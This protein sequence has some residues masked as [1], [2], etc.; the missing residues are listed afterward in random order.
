MKQLLQSL[1]DGKTAVE[2]LPC[3]VVDRG[4]VLIATRKTLISTG[5]EKMLV[6]FGKSGIVGKARQQPDKVR[7]VLE[8]IRTDGLRPTIEAVIHKLDQPIPLGYCNVGSVVKAGGPGT[9]FSE[10]DRVVCN[11]KHAEIVTS[12]TN[13]CAKVPDSVSDEE[14]SLTVIAAIALQGVRLLKPTLGECVVVTGLGLV[15]LITVQL[16][17]ANGCRVLGIDFDP[18]RL[19]LARKFGAETVDLSAGQDP[20]ATARL[21]SRGRGVDGVI[22]TAATKSNE[23]IHQAAVMCRKRGR[24]ILVGVTGLDLSRAD[25]Y[26]KELSFQVSCS[27]GPGR[28]DADYEEKGFDYPIGFVRWTEQRNFEAVLDL[29]AD[30]RLDLG[31]MITHRIKIAEAES[32]YEVMMSDSASL[33]ILLE[34]PD[35]SEISQNRTVK[36]YPDSASKRSGVS[37]SESPKIA[38][39]G[40]GNYAL[41]A[42]I[43]A[44][45]KAGADLKSVV[46]RQGVTGLH[47]AR[48]FGFAETTTDVDEV[49]RDPDIDAVVICTRHNT[50]ANL[51]CDA[52][53]AGKHVFVEK[54]LA[55][56]LADIDRIEAQIQDAGVPAGRIMVGFNRRYSPAIQ[57]VARAM[58][59]VTGPKAIVMSVNS[60]A[61]PADH[62]IQDPEIGGG[63]LVGEACHFVDLLRFLTKSTIKGWQCFV[64]DAETPDTATIQLSFADGSIGTIHYFSNGN[65]AMSKER[66]EV[67]CAGRSLTMTNYR[68]IESYGWPGVKKRQ[69]FRFDKGQTACVDAFV[70]SLQDDSHDLIPIDELLEVS[71]ISIELESLS[72]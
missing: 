57:E 50:H 54:P 24:I 46:S 56:T 18:E 19:S 61:I 44:F 42:L 2:E 13:L 32:A 25:F 14:A 72:W 8:K 64:M 10:G 27:Y 7:M 60:G 35:L 63:R 58:K 4:Q 33:G 52:I 15:G 62:W 31:E 67:T 49:L 28:H 30:K 68:R 41:G 71:R 59:S 48:K 20:V 65:K 16:L 5:T 39:I 17:R 29:M 1:K 66:L 45:K 38:F 34:Y 6:D 9:G 26:E 36:L 55:L 47:A 40:A 51:V 12:P 43:P 70:S 37:E 69:K 3:P 21:F 23:P 11:G 53:A 22:L